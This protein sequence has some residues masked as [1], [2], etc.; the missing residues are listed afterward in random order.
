MPSCGL[1]DQA[2]VH[3]AVARLGPSD[4]RQ[5]EALLDRVGAKDLCVV[6]H[7]M[8][9]WYANAW[10]AAVTRRI[11]AHREALGTAMDLSPPVGA[12]R[13]FKVPGDSPLARLKVGERTTM[14]VERNGGA[15]S[16]T[17]SRAAADLYAGGQ[18]RAIK[19]GVPL[20]VRLVGGEGVRAFIAPP[21]KSERWFNVLYRTTMGTAGRDKHREHA[22][23]APAVRVEV[24]RVGR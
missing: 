23:H 17:L 6:L 3:A 19:G 1:K 15:S 8:R 14:R 11:L 20:V 24:V 12:Y 13:G 5:A 21:E 10:S 16:W 22:V 9:R 18:S 4:R 7:S 2:V